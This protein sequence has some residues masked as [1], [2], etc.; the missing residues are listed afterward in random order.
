M[1]VTVLH[2]ADLHIDSPLRGLPP[3]PL[4][5]QARGATR[6]AFEALIQLALDERVAIVLL[7]GDVFDGDWRDAHT[8]IYFS[9]QIKRLTD[10]AV[11]VFIARGN[12]DAAS[13]LSRHVTLPAGAR[14]FGHAD[15][16]TID[17]PDLGI[18]VH[19]WSFPVESVS[20]NPLPRF[21][22]PLPARVNIGVLHTNIDGAQ[23]HGNYAP[24]RS[25]ELFAHGYDYWALGHVHR[26]TVLQQGDRYVVYPGNLQGRHIRE[27]IA[28]RGEG[29]GVTLFS[30]DGGRIVDVRHRPVDVLRWRPVDVDTSGASHL[31]EVAQ[32]VGDAV[33]DAMAGEEM[34]LAV[35]V[36]L[37]GATRAHGALQV[38]VNELRAAIE[39]LLPQT[40][41]VLLED[42]EVRTR[43]AG[44]PISD[45]LTE[46]LDRVHRSITADGEARRRF[47]A[48]LTADLRR[49]LE[50]A[51]P[52]IR[53]EL[54]SE[55]CLAPLLRTEA[56]ALPV[57][58]I[59]E[60]AR[61][62]LL[63]ALR[64]HGPARS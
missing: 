42:I 4:G 60:Q 51:P 49:L 10:A 40:T 14:M 22:A 24:T 50:N 11:R 63:H 17:L 32:L 20:E 30:V 7:A 13:T 27:D 39:A 1:A 35:R 3:G 56:G 52:T 25:A 62:R 46:A 48:A 29:K 37:S 5:E 34:P 44:P 9:K 38:P 43:P 57:D 55:P 12:H 45:A 15:P 64:G 47:E 16:E 58:T 21:P 6:R 33:A 8:G 54:R 53:E 23:A 36:R 28:A 59:A 61:E 2:A 41:P 31:D 19:G 26:R 18:A